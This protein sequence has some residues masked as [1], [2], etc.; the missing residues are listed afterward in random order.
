MTL[1]HPHTVGFVTGVLFQHPEKSS[2]GPVFFARGKDCRYRVQVFLDNDAHIARPSEDSLLGAI[3]G[4]ALI[5]QWVHQPWTRPLFHG[6]PFNL[7]EVKGA[8]ISRCTSVPKVVHTWCAP[9]TSRDQG[10]LTEWSRNL[11]R[12]ANDVDDNEII[13]L[14]AADSGDRGAANLGVFAIYSSKRRHVLKIS[15]AA[16]AYDTVRRDDG[17]FHEFD[18]EDLG[19]PPFAEAMACQAWLSQIGAAPGLSGVFAGSEVCTLMNRIQSQTGISIAPAH[20]RPLVGIL[21]EEVPD[22]WNIPKRQMPPPAIGVPD[23]RR[24]LMSRINE[25][26]NMCNALDIWADDVQ[27]FVGHDGRAVLGD[28]DMFRFATQEDHARADGRGAKLNDFQYLSD[29]VGRVG[30]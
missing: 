25:L 23:A 19:F 28:L 7:T 22:A 2:D 21:M 12:S 30:Q 5:D 14:N 1:I 20:S 24:F 3:D 9:P 13:L 18:G 15:E 16:F 27:V 29:A 26:G 10:V 17:T 6:R 8:L 4:N 11:S